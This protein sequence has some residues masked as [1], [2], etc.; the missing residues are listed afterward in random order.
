MRGS[1]RG[2]CVDEGEVEVG[3]VCEGRRWGWAV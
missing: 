1:W 2:G 3:C